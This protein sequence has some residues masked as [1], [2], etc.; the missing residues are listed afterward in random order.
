[1]LIV[2]PAVLGMDIIPAFI[3][4]LGGIGAG[5]AYTMVRILG[6]RKE[7]GAFIVFFFSGFSCLVTLPFLVWQFHPMSFGQTAILLLAGLCAAGGQFSITAAYYYAPA[8]E[9]SVYDYTQVVFSAVLGYFIFGQVPDVYSWL[10]YLVICG[11][12]VLMFLYQ[13]R[14]MAR[15]R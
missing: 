14:W 6:E 12:G 7:K 2:K 5:A 3:G 11:M 4:L 8:R 10:G 1:M 15:G 13:N 9:V